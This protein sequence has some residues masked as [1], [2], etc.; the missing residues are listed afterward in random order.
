MHQKRGVRNSQNTMAQRSG[1][2]PHNSNWDSTFLPSFFTGGTLNSPGVSALSSNNNG[3][4]QFTSANTT[5]FPGQEDHNISSGSHQDHTLQPPFSIN[6]VNGTNSKVEYQ[7]QGQELLKLLIREV[8]PE[9]KKE[10]REETS[11][12]ITDLKTEM[13]RMRIVI[14]EM[15]KRLSVIPEMEKRLSSVAEMEKLWTQWLSYL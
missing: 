7:G 1:Q 12:E 11:D 9:V 10:I 6:S 15:E 4:G 13:K 14:A 3:H 5:L 2:S 8:K